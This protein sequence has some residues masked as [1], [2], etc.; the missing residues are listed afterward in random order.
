MGG[1]P[2]PPIGQP[3]SWQTQRLPA[4]LQQGQESPSKLPRSTTTGSADATVV[5]ATWTATASGASITAGTAAAGIPGETH[6]AAASGATLTTGTSSP[7]LLVEVTAEALAMT[8]GQA[9]LAQ[10]H[11]A[12]ASGDSA[13]I[14]SANAERI[15]APYAG[16]GIPIG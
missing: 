8:A 7:A 4:S 5:E 15:L 10:L 2:S 1:R 12:L 13:A 11:A 16:W 6:D 14:G 3:I 9:A